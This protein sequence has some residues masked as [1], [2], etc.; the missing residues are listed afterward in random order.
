MRNTLTQMAQ[1]STPVACP[2]CTLETANADEF[3]T[4]LM[5]EHR[6]SELAT[7]VLEMEDSRQAGVSTDEQLEGEADLDADTDHEDEAVD[8]EEELLAR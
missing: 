2:W 7:Y 5:V 6:K 1:P 3:R 8:R 4:H